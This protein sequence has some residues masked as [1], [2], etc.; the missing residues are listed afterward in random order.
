M[1]TVGEIQA[2]LPKL[3]DAELTQ[4]EHALHAI[5]RQRK[6]GIVY[7]D[8]YGVLTEGDLL[9]EAAAAFKAYDEEERTDANRPPRGGLA[10]TSRACRENPT[11]P[12]S[13][14]IVPRS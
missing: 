11:R 6:T 1:S 9:R 5:Y 8:F 3:S 10:S 12:D 7:D 13:K 4:V 14:C 2:A